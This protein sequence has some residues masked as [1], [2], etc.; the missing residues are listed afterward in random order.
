MR[1]ISFWSSTLLTRAP[2]KQPAD[3]TQCHWPVFP[4]A[5]GSTGDTGARGRPRRAGPIG[6]TKR[7]AP[8]KNP[9]KQRHP[10]PALALGMGDAKS[11]GDPP[12][13][14]S[15]FPPALCAQTLGSHPNL[16]AASFQIPAQL[17][18]A[19]LPP[20]GATG[21]APAVDFR[22]LARRSVPF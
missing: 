8:Q 11:Q 22:L 17:R 14:L 6:K 18:A 19:A 7:G 9:P 4:L 15:P 5:L 1:V 21:P 3:P 13:L 12:V 10:T 2:P 20:S 16:A